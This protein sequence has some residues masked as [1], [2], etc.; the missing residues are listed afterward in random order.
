M[1]K[2]MC[3]GINI[4]YE[5][6]GASTDKPIVLI[7][8]VGTQLTRWN[9]AFVQALVDEGFHVIRLDNRDIGLSDGHDAA[10]VPDYRQV[11]AAKSR[12]EPA[13]VPYT[14][15]DMADDVAAL[16]DHLSI[17]RAHV[18]G[19]SM[20][21]MIAQLVAV[22]HPSRTASLT[23][24]MS[25]SGNPD[26][27]KATD[28]ASQALT[29]RS[30]DPR[31]NREAFL[32]EAVVRAQVIG[33]PGYPEDAAELRARAAEDLDRSFRPEGFARQYA[34]ILAAPDRRPALRELRLPTLVVHGADDP[35][36]R[37]EGGRD[38]AASVPG[39]RLLEIPGMGH[40]IPTAL[41]A[42]IVAA[43]TALAARS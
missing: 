37:V 14:L 11:L 30:A 28:A 20:G 17:E 23:S 22:R 40:N 3:N 9:E 5:V 24:I 2:A 39:A 19:S 32:D 7:S 29:L 21:G 41:N 42:P 8:G 10:G 34:A 33:S 43:I 36:V 4:H 38:T 15:D 26:I 18:V 12:G 31:E 27:P 13:A 25:T 16:L 1:P 6:S 35:L